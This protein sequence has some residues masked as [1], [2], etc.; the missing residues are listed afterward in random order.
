MSGLSQALEV[1]DALSRLND[2]GSIS[3]RLSAAGDS[4]RAPN[5]VQRQIDHAL[6]TRIIIQVGISMP[7]GRGKYSAKVVDTK[8]TEI[9]FS[10]L[11]AVV[12]G[13]P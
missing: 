5:K 13:L 11:A 4:M 6:G 3:E 8:L 10:Q 2:V 12:S 9:N 7:T 1:K